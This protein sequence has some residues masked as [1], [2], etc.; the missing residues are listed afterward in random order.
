M[1]DFLDD[2]IRESFKELDEKIH[3]DTEE[4]Y[5]RFLA[6]IK[7]RTSQV[8]TTNTPQE[9]RSRA[10][11][12]KLLIAAGLIGAFILGNIFTGSVTAAGNVIKTYWI[13]GSN[14]LRSTI[15]IN[16]GKPVQT[17]LEEEFKSIEEIKSRASFMIREISDLPAGVTV[18]KITF[19]KAD[20]T[21]RILFYMR[22]N[23]KSLR[24]TQWLLTG[25]S[26]SVSVVDSS[27]SEIKKFVFNNK[28]YDIVVFKN[29]DIIC[30]FTDDQLLI[31]VEAKGFTFDEFT[32]ALTSIK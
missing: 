18:E 25:S 31:M 23:G 12:S 26:S 2:K 3:V 20:N 13:R 8:P 16:E 4:A 10:N 30:K 17:P 9:K 29:G 6:K 27:N 24:F 11:Y 21:E 7:E 19:Q 5:N 1:S 14:L 28:V 22:G 32:K 15:N